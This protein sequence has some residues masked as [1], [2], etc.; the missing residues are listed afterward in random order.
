MDLSTVRVVRL[1][2]VYSFNLLVDSIEFGEE[3]RLELGPG[4]TAKQ[5]DGVLTILGNQKDSESGQVINM[6]SAIMVTG[7]SIT[8]TSDHPYIPVEFSILT[9]D[10]QVPIK[11]FLNPNR[12]LVLLAH[13]TDISFHVPMSL[14]ARIELIE[15]RLIPAALDKAAAKAQRKKHKASNKRKAAQVARRN[16]RSPEKIASK[17]AAA[18]EAELEATAAIAAGTE[19][20]L[21]Y[22]Q[23]LTDFRARLGR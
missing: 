7:T 5:D 15:T 6:P 22:Q 1:E 18:R 20:V 21:R 11:F 3:E 12:K 23:M 8:L 9:R 14:A 13:K 2:G 10:P 17:E 4:L 19:K 16:N